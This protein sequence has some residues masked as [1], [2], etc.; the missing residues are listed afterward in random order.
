MK[1]CSNCGN[2][3]AWF[4]EIEGH[5]DVCTFCCY[6]YHEEYKEMYK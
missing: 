5:S 6:I 4:C 2:G 3:R 1:Q